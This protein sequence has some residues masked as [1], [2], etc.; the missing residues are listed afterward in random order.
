MQKI[1]TIVALGDLLS[2]DKGF[3]FTKSTL[4]QKY[5]LQCGPW[6]PP[7]PLAGVLQVSPPRNEDL[8]LGSPLSV[9]TRSHGPPLHHG[10]Q[11][12][13]WHNGFE[14]PR[15]SRCRAS[16]PKVE[17]STPCRPWIAAA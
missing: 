15:R 8:L 4:E 10:E 14:H 12:T 17:E 2:K 11:I 13:L 5:I 9:K 3:L 7:P 6:A 16:D 1:L